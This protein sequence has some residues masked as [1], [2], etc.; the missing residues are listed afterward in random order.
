MKNKNKNKYVLKN[1]IN[2][3]W[4]VWNGMYVVPNINWSERSHIII[5]FVKR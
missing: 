5:L 1:M 2:V 4:N 3:N